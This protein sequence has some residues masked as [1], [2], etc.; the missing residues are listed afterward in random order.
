MSEID[1]LIQEL[2]DTI[3]NQRE[4]IDRLN[5]IIDELNEDIPCLL[6]IINRN[7]KDIK[8]YQDEW[9]A[10]RGTEERLKELKENK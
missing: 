2:R 6:E 1:L 8:I 5:N 3:D 7:E 9:I 10:V 4:E